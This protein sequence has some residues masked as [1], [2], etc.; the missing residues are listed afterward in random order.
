MQ[1]HVHKQ[2]KFVNHFNKGSFSMESDATV[3]ITVIH[4]IQFEV[5]SSNLLYIFVTQV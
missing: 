5:T 1:V 2:Q 3:I 4:I